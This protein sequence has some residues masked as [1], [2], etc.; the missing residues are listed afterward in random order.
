M[1]RQEIDEKEFM[2]LPRPQIDP[3]E[4]QRT[5][6]KVGYVLWQVQELEATVGMYLVLVHKLEPGAAR[7]EAEAVLEKS[8][9][10][11][12]G[13]LLSELKTKS[14]APPGLV[15]RLDRFVPRRNWLAHHS[16][17]DSHLLFYPG[18]S[19]KTVHDRLDRIDDEAL[20]LM[21]GFTAV[22]EEFIVSVGCTPEELEAE[23]RRVLQAWGAA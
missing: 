14:T 7:E 15:E 13:Q 21:K 3:L 8:R 17:H 23:A 2:E 22:L 18:R 5:W 4:L 20:A 6:Q 10:R 12:L 9:R 11:T 1:S 16:R 19:A